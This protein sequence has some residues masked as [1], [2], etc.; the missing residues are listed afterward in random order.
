MVRKKYKSGSD[1]ILNYKYQKAFE[2]GKSVKCYLLTMQ[3]WLK[4]AKATFQIGLIDF[5]FIVKSTTC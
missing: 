5:I 2:R 1:D 3:M 4:F